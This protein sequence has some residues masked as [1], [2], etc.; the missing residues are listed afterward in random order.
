MTEETKRPIEE[1]AEEIVETES[2]SVDHEEA[3]HTIKKPKMD[4][5]PL[6]T[7]P[8]SIDPSENAR[9]EALWRSISQNPKSRKYGPKDDQSRGREAQTSET[10]DQKVN[11][12][13]EAQKSR[14]KKVA[15]YMSYSGTGYVGMQMYVHLFNSIGSTFL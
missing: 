15:L 7:S 2:P 3:T 11:G 1:T 9:L 12:E 8:P 13:T 4:D 10:L 5:E 14:K 6:L